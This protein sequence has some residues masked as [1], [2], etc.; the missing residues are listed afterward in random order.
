MDPMKVQAIVEWA[1]PTTVSDLRSFLGLANYYRRFIKDYS[2]VAAPL[3]D[4]LKKNWKWN[5]TDGY[6]WAFEKLKRAVTSAPVLKLPDF[7]R[8]FEVHTD[9]SDRAIGGVLVQEGHPVAF[10][11]RKLNEAEQRYSTHE[12][13]MTVV[14]HCLGVW[15][16]YL[17]G[18][19]FVVKT[20]NMANTFFKT[21]KKLS[22]RQARWQEFLAEYDFEWKHK[23]G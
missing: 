5:W 16:V 6:R 1:A 22:Q 15:R 20:D 7:E 19:K 11:S 8:P 17:L 13:E 18:P 3:S 12:K 14:V 23:P 10:E 21:Q 4:L 2:K 9:A